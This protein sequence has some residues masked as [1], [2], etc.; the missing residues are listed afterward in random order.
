[1]VRG[2]S[3]VLLGEV[4]AEKEE[5]STRLEKIQPRDF[6]SLSADTPDNNSKVEWDF[7][8]W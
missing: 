6:I 8:S 4:D 7:E 1:M 2:D 3:I 5:T